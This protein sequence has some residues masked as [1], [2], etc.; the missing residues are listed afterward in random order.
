MGANPFIASPPS[1]GI[2]DP[3][4]DK[5]NECHKREIIGEIAGID[6]TLQERFQMVPQ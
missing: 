3:V 5:Q 1:P 4:S 2:E 6:D